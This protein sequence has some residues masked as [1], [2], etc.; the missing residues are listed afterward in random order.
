MVKKVLLHYHVTIMKD[1]VM[2]EIPK[3]QT[4]TFVILDPQNFNFVGS[5]PEVMLAKVLMENDLIREYCSF[6]SFGIFPIPTELQVIDAGDKPK[7]GGKSKAKASSSEI[8]RV[9]KKT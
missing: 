2:A 8:V 7:G 1:P 5:I 6:P 9:S 4:T 3:L